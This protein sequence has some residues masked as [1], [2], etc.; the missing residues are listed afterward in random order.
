VSTTA[1][2]RIVASFSYLPRR[3]SERQGQKKAGRRHVRV[4]LATLAAI[5]LSY[6]IA[7]APTKPVKRILILNEVGTSYPATKIINE[8]IQTALQN[9]PYQLEFYSEYLDTILFPDPAAQQEFRDFYIRKYQ[10]R[11]PDVIVTVGPSS[12]KFMQEVHQT[13]FAGVPIIFCLP[14]GNVPGTPKLDSD[15]TGVEID[16]APAETLE[17]ALRLQPG[18]KHVVV[19]S[20]VSE[21]DKQGQA[22][23]MQH[24]QAFTDQIDIRYLTDL[25]MPDMLERLRQLPNHT[26]VL[27]ISVG[28][29]AAGI[30]F[31]SNEAGTMVAEA[32]NAP[33]FSLFDVFLN[34]GEVGGDL[35]Q[36]SEQGRVAGVM[37]LRTLSGERPQEHPQGKGCNHP[38]V[39]LASP[40]ALGP[41]RE[42]SS[43]REHGPQSAVSILGVLQALYYRKRFPDPGGDALDSRAGM[44]EGETH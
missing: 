31:K 19:V 2:Y 16:M 36:L 12:L 14:H 39:R 5:V 28:Q 17:I 13:A 26:V 44:A 34:H 18:T 11:R 42:R 15:F 1:D 4:L 22:S 23:V 35:S 43:R 29:D 41:Q 30:R 38:H 21:F 8:G 3:V 10:N 9:S 20:G 32:A 25:A 6:P 37:A 7:A 40:E 24:L 33:V 27:L